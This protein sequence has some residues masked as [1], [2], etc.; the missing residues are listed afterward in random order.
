MENL[1]FRLHQKIRFNRPVDKDKDSVSPGGYELV[2]QDEQ[3]KEVSVQFDFEDYIGSVLEDEPSIVEC[4]QKNPDYDTFPG[5]ENITEYMLRHV[6]RCEEWF[7]YTGED[8]DLA[9]VEILEPIFVLYK[10]DEPVEI[11]MDIVIVPSC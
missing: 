9:P 2:M 3:G 6:V 8:G 10:D 1:N 4:E 5:L 7:I 11:P